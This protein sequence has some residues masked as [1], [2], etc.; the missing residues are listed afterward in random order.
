VYLIALL[1]AEQQ[2]GTTSAGALLIAQSALTTFAVFSGLL[3]VP[4]IVPPTKFWVGGS[5]LSGDWRPALLALGMLVVFLIL[6]AI[7]AIRSFFSL[8]ALDIKSYILIGVAA[9]IWGFIQRW[10]WRIRL[11]ER[12]LVSV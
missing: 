11:L 6:V 1:L 4:F 2:M 7:P 9:M 5:E 8:A 3:L 10:L 12:F